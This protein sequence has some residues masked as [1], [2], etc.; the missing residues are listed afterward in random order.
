[1]MHKVLGTLV[2]QMGY[3]ALLLENETTEQN[4]YFHAFVNCLSSI[5][6]QAIYGRFII[7]YLVDYIS[8]VLE[9]SSLATCNFKKIKVQLTK[10]LTKPFHNLENLTMIKHYKS[11]CLSLYL[12]Y[13]ILY[14]TRKSKKES[15]NPCLCGMRTQFI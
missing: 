1:M 9:F 6:P 3:A 10:N 8:I 2:M 14:G 15:Q 11:H 4:T 7:K 13:Y 12:E 5:L